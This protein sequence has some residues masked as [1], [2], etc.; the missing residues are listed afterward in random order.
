MK[1]TT[2]DSQP[3]EDFGK[4]LLRLVL[5]VLILL[6]GIAKVI[7]G[8]AFILKVATDAGLPAAFGYMVYIGEVLAPLLLIFGAWTRLAAL[9]IAVNMVFAIWLVHAAEVFTLNK[10]GGWSLEL[11]GMFLVTA[12]ALVFLGAGRYSVAGRSGKLN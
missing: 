5:G 7:G 2:I 8:P 1:E 3:A 4:L 10:Q 9:I 6:H 11:Q 12:I